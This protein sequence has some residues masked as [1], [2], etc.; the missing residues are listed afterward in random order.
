[1][2][3]GANDF[4]QTVKLF[5]LHIVVILFV[6]RLSIEGKRVVGVLR[7]LLMENIVLTVV[8]IRE[9]GVVRASLLN[10]F[11]GTHDLN[12]GLRSRFTLVAPEPLLVSRL[13]VH[14]VRVDDLRLL[15]H[16]KSL[17]VVLH[18]SDCKLVVVVLSIVG[19]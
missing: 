1:M 7:A 4:I 17:L 18:L 13:E 16:V 9:R 11:G 14:G 5:R 6:R 12:I 2:R 19:E 10:R 15:L 8:P 3:V